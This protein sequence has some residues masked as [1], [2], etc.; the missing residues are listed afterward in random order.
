MSESKTPL[1][2]ALEREWSEFNPETK[3]NSSIRTP[4]TFKNLARQL[5]QQLASALVE[6]DEWRSTCQELREQQ[7]SLDAENSK[8]IQQQL[9]DRYLTQELN[10]AL[11]LAEVMREALRRIATGMNS[12][13][14]CEFIA[15]KAALAT[16]ADL[17]HL[18]VVEK[19]ELEGLNCSCDKF[20]PISGHE[21]VEGAYEKCP[22]CK[23]KEKVKI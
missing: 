18:V 8:L 3:G 12:V 19:K 20:S 22:A 21:Y 6:R 16:P 14:D 2:D 5:E 7:T 4:Q 15:R 9:A 10:S 13:L 17:S 23:L 11:A 1:T